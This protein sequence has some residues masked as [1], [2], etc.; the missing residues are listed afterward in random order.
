[1]MTGRP[2]RIHLDPLD[3]ALLLALDADP[4]APVSHL[5]AQLEVS[6]RTTARRLGRLVQADA[7]RVLGRTL[8]TFGG[9]IARLVRARG[10]PSVLDGVARAVAA[11]PDSRWVRLSEDRT[12]L[13]CGIVT[14][15]PSERD[16]LALLLEDT[17]LE[18]A[19]VAD[20]LH[21][22]SGTRYAVD[23][24]QRTLDVIDRKILAALAPDGRMESSVLACRLGLDPSTVSRRRRRL[25]DEGVM[26]LEADIHPTALAT[27]GDAMLWLTVSPGHVRTMGSA[28]RSRRG[29]RF[30][31]ATSGTTAL[32]AHVTLPDRA[33]LVTFVDEHLGHHSVSAAEI[34]PMGEVLKRHI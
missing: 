20:L 17:R 14:E 13:M 28:L 3:R 24:P 34:V 10:R 32:V 5:A 4:G 2:L 33:D 1:M 26:Y 6:A 11:R 30:T 19:R 18:R 22:W 21:V 12:E 25:L 31:A 23:K 29:V 15:A 7:V 27:V 9:D 16:T 8:P